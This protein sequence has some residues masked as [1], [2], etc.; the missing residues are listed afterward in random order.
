MAKLGYTWY[1]KDWGNS[2]NVFDLNLSE[3]GL[4]REFI[5]LAMLN[6]N[7]IEIKKSFWA[8]KF[9]ASLEDID[10]IL[11]KLISLKLVIII[12]DILFVP[13]CESRLNLVRGGSNGGKKS[14]PITKPILK[15]ITK[16]SESL[17]EKKQKPIS[18]QIET[19]SKEKE[20]KI[21]NSLLSEI[22]ILKESNSISIDKDIF[23]F[24]PD[25]IKYI[26]IASQFQ[27][28]FIKNLKDKGSPTTKQDKATYK[29]YVT[30]IRLMFEKEE[31]TKDQLIEAYNFLNSSDGE[32]WKSIILNTS[33]L[34]DKIDVIIAKKNT[35][36][37]FEAKKESLVLNPSKRNKF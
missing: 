32:F 7:K 14:K 28:L 36:S 24:T 29:D 6:D 21:N 2:E 15:P 5:D 10:S 26:S 33:Q 25:V 17:S 23:E 9:C 1:P 13:S 12:D 11:Y 3:R 20:N 30:P 4:Y 18:K 37:N 8:R 31:A 27:K 22:I 19:K 35:K 34:R 16:P